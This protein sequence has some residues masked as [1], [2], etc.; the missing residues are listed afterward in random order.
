[1][2][3]ANRCVKITYTTLFNQNKNG[4]KNPEAIVNL[5]LFFKIVKLKILFGVFDW[6]VFKQAVRKEIKTSKNLVVWLAFDLFSAIFSIPLL[7]FIYELIYKKIFG[8]NVYFFPWLNITILRC[9][10]FGQLQKKTILHQF[11]K[12][13]YE[14]TWTD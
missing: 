7:Y 11:S 14:V 1:M 2:N 9:N 4:I 13:N 12:Y 5:E 3:L 8:L 10:G 6:K